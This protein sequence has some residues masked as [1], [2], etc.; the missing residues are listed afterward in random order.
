MNRTRST[1]QSLVVTILATLVFAGNPAAHAQHSGDIGLR[2]TDGN[3]EVYGPI[4]NPDTGGLYLG[5]FGDSGFPGFTSNPGFDAFPG[6]FPGGRIGF[7]VRAG[8]SRWDPAS[9]TWLDPTQVGEELRI[10]FITLQVDV[11]DTPVAGF[12]L[13]VQS[14]GGWHKHVNFILQPDENGEMA[15]GVYRLDLVL[16]STAGI[17][18]SQPFT[19]LFDFEADSQDVDDALAS[20][21]PDPPCLGDLNGDG[22]VGGADFG[23]ILALW[24]SSDPN[25]DLTGDGIVGGADVGTLLAVWGD[26][27]N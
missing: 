2:V 11:Q 5:T 18:D 17:G 3:L 13:A 14:D 24:G 15:A 10:T 27:P 20:F 9:G 12:D 1:L 25:A 4:G 16:Y 19:I 6:T 23:Q 21:E 8:L 7:N 26:C 22:L